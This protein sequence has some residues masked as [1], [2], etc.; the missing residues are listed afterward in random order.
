MELLHKQGRGIPLTLIAE[1]KGDMRKVVRHQP[2]AMF[3]LG[4]GCGCSPSFCG[5]RRRLNPFPWM[6]V[7]LSAYY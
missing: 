2:E 7:L 5:C 1:G 3:Q 4:N 6:Q